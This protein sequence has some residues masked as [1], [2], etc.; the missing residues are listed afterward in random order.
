MSA[1]QQKQ[2]NT[3][4]TRKLGDLWREAFTE[5]ELANVGAEI[6]DII[7]KLE[8]E[9]IDNQ[10]AE[11]ALQNI[12]DEEGAEPKE[13][14]IGGEKH[15]LGVKVEDEEFQQHENFKA[16]I[17]TDYHPAQSEVATEV[18]QNPADMIFRTENLRTIRDENLPE[19]HVAYENG[20]M[21]DFATDGYADRNWRPKARYTGLRSRHGERFDAM[22]WPA[23]TQLNTGTP[24]GDDK[25]VEEFFHNF[26]NGGDKPS[27]LDVVPGVDALFANDPILEEYEDD[28]YEAVAE[29]SRD[30]LYD[31]FVS[32]SPAVL[33]N[34]T[35][36]WGDV[37]DEALPTN[38]NYGNIEDLSDLEDHEDYI[39]MVM[40]RPMILSPEIDASDIQ[41]LD[42]NTYQPEGTFEEEYGEDTTWVMPGI[43]GIE[44]SIVTFEQF[45][46]DQQY[47]G[48][49]LVE[50]NGEEVMKPVKVDHSDLDRDSFEELAGIGND[51]QTGYFAFQNTFV[52]PDI[53]PKN[54]GIVEFRSFS[55][56]PRSYEALVTQKS[57]MHVYEDV[58][59][60]FHEHGLDSENALEFREDAKRNGLDAQLPSGATVGDI[61]EEDLVDV[62]AEGVRESFSGEMPYSFELILD[63]VGE[64]Y[65]SFEGYLESE[66]DSLSEFADHTSD[67]YNS[68]DIKPGF[69]SKEDFEKEYNEFVDWFADSYKEEMLGYVDE[70]SEAEKLEKLANEKTPQDAFQSQARPNAGAD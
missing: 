26:F 36:R 68:K 69:Y 14:E 63:D 59:D 34:S 17:D 5:N 16:E 18:F 9:P 29:G 55:N 50:E 1:S 70:G 3:G 53:A 62:L 13:R 11:K 52:R 40:E 7:R 66:F 4:L 49:V 15:L 67:L 10:D 46:K 57:L 25:T 42:E 45:A 32:N 8:D 12:V 54:D 19:G 21:P 60:V 24:V 44:E 65:D 23:S 51:D 61:Y 2:Q 20:I 47:L 33:R 64:P 35:E 48:E 30:A 58:Q 41:V 38:E 22:G 37:L 28:L 39:E 56:S 43:S 27:M 31:L 6:E